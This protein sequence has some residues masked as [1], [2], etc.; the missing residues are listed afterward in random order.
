[1]NAPSR[2]LP[3]AQPQ[4]MRK[5]VV[6]GFLGT[7][8]EY[9]DFFIYGTAAA[10]V[11]P[12][13][14]FPALGEAAATA[15]SF[16]TFA[17]AFLA[18]PL[19]GV[20]FG[21]IG[22]R[23]GRK[24]TLVATLMIMGTA[25]VLI[26]LLPSAA[27][28]G[29]AAPILL[30]ILRF[31]QGLAVG[32]EWSSAALFVGEYAPRNKR[33]LYALSP[34]LGTGAGL[35]LSTLT[36]LITGLTMSNAAF[37]AWGWRIPFLLS[38][39]LVAVGLWIRLG[40]AETPVFKAAMA[41][42]DVAAERRAPFMEMLRHQW[43][44]VLL[45]AGAVLMWLAFFYIGAVYLTNYGTTRLGFTRTTMLV[46]N[47]VAI[48]VLLVGM[49]GG[50]WLSD[51]YGRKPLL[52]AVNFF[53]VA[54]AFALFPIVNTG[55][56]FL[57]A[58]A[59]SVTLFLAGSGSGTTTAFLPEI[60]HTGYRSTATGVSFN[61][62]SVVGGALPPIIAAPLIAAY[63]SVALSTILAVLAFVAGVSVLLL[64]ETRGRDLLDDE[65]AEQTPVPRLTPRT[66]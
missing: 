60:F 54:W 20:V 53:A 21:E 9:Y 34:A 38:A 40:I 39:V 33:G 56:T 7:T 57:V 19:G 29:V 17:V 65:S 46:I 8:I 4:N 3:P 5:V 12:T 43:R 32:G 63:G 25:T 18:R 26:G 37:T 51:R 15:A 6:A 52:L 61:M 41:R 59:V 35:L 66:T 44:Q 64:R 31:L 2:D 22:D 62:G 16:G 47:L 23:V 27:T 1:M 24:T 30:I 14:F 42:A 13:V 58:L 55:N 10:L 36:F 50:G 45:A 11:F 49:I 28:I 48:L